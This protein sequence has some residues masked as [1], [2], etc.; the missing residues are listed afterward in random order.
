MGQI[1][2]FPLCRNSFGEDHTFKQE[3]SLAAFA[4]VGRDQAV[5]RLVLSCLYSVIITKSIHKVYKPNQIKQKVVTLLKTYIIAHC[6]F[7]GIFL[8]ANTNNFCIVVNTN[9]NKVFPL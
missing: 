2:F 9:Y 3:V 4:Y 5:M 1:Q 7:S 8:A 6:I